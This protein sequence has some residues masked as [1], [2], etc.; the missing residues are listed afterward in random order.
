MIIIGTV[1]LLV[2]STLAPMAWRYASEAG[3]SFAAPTTVRASDASS[4]ATA[5]PPITALPVR[6]STRT[7]HRGAVASHPREKAQLAD[8]PNAPVI[9]TAPA[10]SP[11]RLIG[12][13]SVAPPLPELRTGHVGGGLPEIVVS[14]EMPK[15]AEQQIHSGGTVLVKPNPA[16]PSVARLRQIEGE[17]VLSAVIDKEGK[18]QNVQAISG[19]PLLVP[20]AISAAKAMRYTPYRIGNM[21]TQ[22]TTQITF[23]FSL[24][25]REK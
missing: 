4:S 2:F 13:A 15:Y 7:V 21:P 12:S 1:A 22:A 16:Y 25:G 19:H 18:L 24:S 9:S 5:K 17:V 23:Q 8:D 20:A 3:F 14:P 11:V 6:A 10:S